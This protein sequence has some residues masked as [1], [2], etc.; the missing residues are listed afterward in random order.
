MAILGFSLSSEKIQVHLGGEDG[1]QVLHDVEEQEAHDGEGVVVDG[2]EG[3][4]DVVEAHIGYAEL[5]RG[6]VQRGAEER[7][8]FEQDDVCPR[9]RAKVIKNDNDDHFE[10]LIYLLFS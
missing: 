4:G 10:M 9:R 1:C 7:A 8:T 3:G 6:D 5:W 2:K